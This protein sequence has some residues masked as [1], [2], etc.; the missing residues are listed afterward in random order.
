MSYPIGTPFGRFAGLESLLIYPSI[1][2]VA[3]RLALVILG[4][5]AAMSALAAPKVSLRFTVW[6]GDES[7]KVLHR[8]VEQ[9]MKEN[10]DIEVKLES[11]PDYTTYHQKM[12]TQ[13]AGNTAPDVAMMDPGHFTALANR[14]ALLN[15]NDFMKRT[16]G[17]DIGK[18]YKPIVD[19]HSLNGNLYVLPRDIA[20]SGLVYYNKEAFK[21][22]GIPLPDGTWTW[23]FKERPELKEKDF[24]WVMHK[25]TK[26]GSDGKPTRY[27]YVSGWPGLFADTLMY[28]YGLQPANDNQH[29]TKVLY[30]SPEMKK[31]YTLLQDLTLEKK[32]SPSSV[33]V[34]NVLQQNTTSLFV[35]GKVA[36]FQNGIWEVPNV[37]RDMKPDSKEF[38]DWDIAMF[39]A[40][41][42][43]HRGYA[44]GG[45]GYCIF[46]STP[47]PEESWRLCR[48]MA[49]PVGMR[50]MAQAGIAQPAIREVALSDCWIPGPNTPKEQQWP[51]NRIITDTEVQYVNFGPTAEIWPEISAI[52]GSR[53]D[54]VY[55]GLMKPEEAL[56]TGA[57]ESQQRLDAL[58]K[59]ETLP[60]FNWGYGVALG[61]LIIAVV[62]FAVYWPE[63][64][65][66]Y[67]RRQKKENA[68]AYRFLSPWLIGL[69]LF[70]LGPMILSLIMSFLNWDMI[71]PAQWRGVHNYTEAMTED[72]RFWISLKVT[73][74]Y[75]LVSTPLGILI[76]LMLAM[77]LNQKVRGIPLF[78]AMFYIPTIASTVAMTLVTRKIMSPD[79]GLLNTIL[80]N[81]IFEKTLHL[82]SL[83]NQWSGT[84]PGEHVNW[85][86]N[87]HTTMPAVILLSLVGVGGTMLI[88]LAGLQGVPQYYYEAAT[89]DGASAWRRFRSITLPMITPSIFFTMITGF[90]GSF[91]VFTQVFVITNGQGGGPNNSLWVYMIALYSNA[92]Q[93]LRMGYAAALA[94]V[95]FL[96]ILIITLLQM[97]AS[98]RWV[99]Y[100]A[101]AK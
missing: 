12:L 19:A 51:H 59:E 33:D 7:L 32:W 63:R 14:G 92:F 18:Y 99:Y 66:R 48:Y 97:Q 22:A 16:P 35:K 45:S 6:D 38:F 87:E 93:T 11:N 100:E 27:G 86:G 58:L 54:S 84:K 39:P 64:K 5:G 73:A 49:G 88:L 98:K 89:V 40:Y 36:M 34:S 37:R 44:T 82:G 90:I 75:T 28:S 47:H 101:E 26:V 72:P 8:V 42:N 95:L 80:Y 17:F 50:A 30:G 46:S 61:V 56:G 52:M 24:L 15:L 81:P 25:L 83:L 53:Q 91:Q 21:E 76:A 96:I 3:V 4:V 77:L 60:L 13:Y 68:A 79:E 2:K 94:W 62:L 70:T 57:I 31:V 10:P 41:A 74:Y 20:P 71:R 9:F 55:N 67:T 85:L 23:D 43:G 29:P 1:S 65:L 69:C 78:R